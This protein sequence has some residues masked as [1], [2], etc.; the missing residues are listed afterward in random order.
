MS[1]NPIVRRNQGRFPITLIY[2]TSAKVLVVI[3]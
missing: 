3:G 2:Q 1:P